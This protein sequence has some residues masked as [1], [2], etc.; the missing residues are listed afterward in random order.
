MGLGR[1]P[2]PIRSEP[3]QRRSTGW[4]PIALVLVRGVPP[5]VGREPHA[6]PLKDVRHN[7]LPFPQRGHINAT[8]E[9]SPVTSS[10]CRV[11]SARAGCSPLPTCAQ[12]QGSPSDDQ[13]PSGTSPWPPRSNTMTP[14]SG[15]RE[16]ADGSIGV[17]DADMRP[18]EVEHRERSSDLGGIGIRPASPQRPER[19]SMPVSSVI[20][21]RR[22]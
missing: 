21:A 5:P 20:A 13:G 10:V 7:T 16:R 6:R 14:V 19:T 22:M 8:G 2:P 12:L 15:R 1:I 17:G 11:A 4:R 9:S 18:F 3:P